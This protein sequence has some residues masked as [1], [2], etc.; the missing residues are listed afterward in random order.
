M[1][2]LN[3]AIQNSVE[4]KSIGVATSSSQLFRSLGQTIGTAIL[5]SMLTAGVALGL[6]NIS[7]IPY[8]E[9]IVNN[10][11][12]SQVLQGQTLDADFAISLNTIGMKDKIN[13]ATKDIFTKLPPQQAKVAQAEFDKSQDEFGTQVIDAFTNELHKIFWAVLVI[14]GIG[15]MIVTFGIKEHRLRGKLEGTP[16]E[17]TTK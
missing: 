2:T 6:G 7:K 9:N 4:Q 16:G 11:A 13:D 10:P 14:A 5:G 15:S 1:P 8:I 12:S 17:V 3:L